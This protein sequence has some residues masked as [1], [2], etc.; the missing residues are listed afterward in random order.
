MSLNVGLGLIPGLTSLTN[1]LSATSESLKNEFEEMS[2]QHAK[3][4]KQ[5]SPW[6]D[7]ETGDDN[8]FGSLWWVVVPPI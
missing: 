8:Q 3:Y 2:N 6:L 7:H 4:S 1:R 5:I